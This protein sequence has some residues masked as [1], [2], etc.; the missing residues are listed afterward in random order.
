MERP[1]MI[2]C[3]FKD[4]EL[5]LIKAYGTMMGLKDQIVVTWRNGDSL[6]KDVLEGNLLEDCVIEIKDRAIIFNDIP[7]IK[8]STF[9]D[10]MKKMRIPPTLK[11]VVTETSKEWTLTRVLQNF[12]EERKADKEGKE[13]KHI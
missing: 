2:L 13:A 9:I 6:I 10:N 12:V 3:N 5:K 1:C 11:G 8:V 4:K 7:P